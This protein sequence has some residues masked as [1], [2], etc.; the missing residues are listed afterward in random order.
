MNPVNILTALVLL[1]STIAVGAVAYVIYL[2]IT[3]NNDV[4]EYFDVHP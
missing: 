2:A 3:I 4:D 1:F